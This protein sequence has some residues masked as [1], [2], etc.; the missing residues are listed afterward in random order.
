MK[1]LCLKIIWRWCPFYHLVLA[2]SHAWLEL[3]SSLF[4]LTNRLNIS[5]S[6]LIVLRE[7]FCFLSQHFFELY[8]KRSEK[9]RNVDLCE[10]HWA[11][12]IRLKLVLISALRSSCDRY[13]NNFY[14]NQSLLILSSVVM[15]KK[16]IVKQ[17]FIFL[18][19][20]A[21]VTFR[22]YVEFGERFFR[23][24]DQTHPYA[25]STELKALTIAQ[26]SDR[27]LKF[28]SVCCVELSFP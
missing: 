17:L 15:P 6:S 9:R 3:N 11:L 19:F 12:P 5:L 13:L 8:L 1:I 24:H 14:N 16:H 27:H 25:H 21:W 26:G 10:N 2:S 22:K 23:L 7:R 4:L 28:W 20:Q 18:R